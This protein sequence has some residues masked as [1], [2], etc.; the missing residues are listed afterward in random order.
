MTPLLV[1][2]ANDVCYLGSLRSCGA[3]GVDAAAVEYSW[4][5]AGPWY[6]AHSRWVTS[7]ATMSN[8]HGDREQALRDLITVATGIRET[9]GARPL[10]VPS[11]DTNLM[12]LLD[13]AQALEPHLRM[14]G[15]PDHERG[16]PDV[17]GKDSCARLL[18]AGGVAI[19][20][21]FACLAPEDVDPIVEVVP[22]PCIY[23]PRTKD[24]GQTFYARH[25]GEKAVCVD[26]R[27]DLRA[28]LHHELSSGFELVVQERVFFDSAHEEIP[29]YVYVDEHHRIRMAATA[30]K[31]TIQ[32]YPYGTATVLY[33]TWHP[34]LLEHAQ[35]VARALR[36]RG[37]LMIEFIRDKKDGRWKVIEVN[38]RPWLFVDFFRRFG[39]NYLQYLHEDLHGRSSTWPELRVPSPEVLASQ[40]VHVS[41]PKAIEP[42]LAGLG[43]PPTVAD[44]VAFLRT[45]PGART[46]TFLDPTDPAPGRAELTDFAG[47]HGLA[48]RPL[49]DAVEG[50][51]CGS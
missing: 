9:T 25:D 15:S 14:M 3:A 18:E 38:G 44:V 28:R 21:T 48:A 31:H 49:L 32:P 30:V 16:R 26:T 2:R 11:S 23:K 1:L 35:R 10:A 41:L 39:F 43:R 45:L 34:E 33:L 13:H 27:D 40:P 17:V 46:L 51:L 8:P 7:P 50:A 22:Y 36:W 4:P 5:G 12:F 6:S 47:R 37:I 19:P 20:Q 42:F 24:Y 29:V